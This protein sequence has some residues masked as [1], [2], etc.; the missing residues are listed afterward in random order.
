[1]FHQ[2]WQHLQGQKP[3]HQRIHGRAWIHSS[4]GRTMTQTEALTQAL[5]LALIAP[6]DQKADQAATLAEQ[7][8]QGLDFEQVEQSKADALQTLGLT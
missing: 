3:H 5:I 2:I 1:M 4:K 6:D 8:A 7:L